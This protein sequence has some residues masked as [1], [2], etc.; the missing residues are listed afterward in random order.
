MSFLRAVLLLL[1]PGLFGLV[2][3]GPAPEPPPTFHPA[4]AQ[5]AAAL[6]Q[7]DTAVRPV[8]RRE[9]Y[10]CHAGLN[11]KGDFDLD[12]RDRLLKG[13]KHMPVSPAV[14]PGHPEKSLLVH[15]IRQQNLGP[16]EKPMPE[17]GK[18]AD[19]EI[20]AIEKWIADGAIMD[21]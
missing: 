3:C 7:Y 19:S 12:T 11:H 20:A 17:K 21:R 16:D 13:G 1:S 14:V 2:A 8:L 15:L 10:R 18:L 5:E 9:C 6:N 4:N